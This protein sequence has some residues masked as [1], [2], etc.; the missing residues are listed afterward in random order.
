MSAHPDSLYRHG[1]IRVAAAVPRLRLVDPGVNAQRTIALARRAD[2]A[3]AVLVAFPEL[4]LTGYTADDLF[5]QGALLGAVE[6]A[7][8]QIR[9]ASVALTPAIVVG[10]PLRVEQAVINAAVVIAGGEI[11]GVA[12]KSF[13]PEYR[14]FYEKRYF[15][16]ARD[17]V[18][19]TTTVGGREVPLGSDLLFTRESI[20]FAV[21]ICEDVWA[22]IP[23]S[24]Y[25][26]LAGATV[27][28]NLSASNITVG[29]ADYRHAL[30]A[31]QSGRTLSAY[32]YTAAG[33][34]E[35]TTD[36]AWDGQAMIY[37]NGVLLAEAQRFP[38]E[39]SL[40]LAD[41]DQD[42][43]L[44]DRMTT[45]SWGDSVGDYR[46]RLAAMR[47]VRVPGGVP[48][49]AL[50][51]EREIPRFPYVPAD[52]VS[53]NERCSEVYRI[54]VSGLATRM[55][56]TGIERI[57]IGVSGGLDSTHALI[58]AASAMDRLGL[59]REN[60]LAYTMPGFGT[61]QT[62]LRSARALMESLGV[63][64]HELDI[65]P[66]SQAML[67][68]IKHPA[69]RGEPVYDV[70][71]ENVQ[72]GER[73][74]HLFRL[75]N[76]H[77]GLVLGTGDLSELA[78]GWATYGVGDQMS[79]YAVNASVPKTLIQFL[80]RWAIDTDQF[81]A[82][83]GAVLEAVIDTEISPELIPAADG[84]D[85]APVQRSE[86][87]VGPYELQDFFLYYTL[88]FGY[89]PSKVAWLAHRAWG[90]RERGRWPDL[91]PET[92]RNA[93]SREQITHW[94]EVFLDRFFRT[95]QFKRSA[96]PN[97]P[98]VGSGGS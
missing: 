57:V 60:I 8:E 88:R 81:G 67:E 70:T 27:L 19:T 52:P 97:A 14:E 16:P 31:G 44:A 30:A 66:A 77:N 4:G 35:S 75:A 48:E 34:G 93:Y 65:R 87:K 83:T 64:A 98:K 12:P 42:R 55:E 32:L 85:A 20:T 86:A 56:A 22:P 94:L 59:P 96:I 9:A 78:L 46:D 61:S 91:I 36:L 39:D 26:A 21:E 74:S 73:T 33:Y 15:R 71:Y 43:L 1:F 72:A 38:T 17:L 89:A 45:S 63:S 24:T 79:H 51:L 2:S 5:H 10:A 58:V 69:G 68:A 18:H 62:T 13:L 53:R 49:A 37:E 80:L 92:K 29:K 11:L 82:A 7:I 28:V 84:D 50:A 3:G 95:S 90:D 41:V 47:R 23:P 76:L 6:A 40:I 25:H 54:Q